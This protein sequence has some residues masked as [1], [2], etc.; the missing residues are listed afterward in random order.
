[1]SCKV[2]Y[3]DGE[4]SKVLAPNGAES[5][6]FKDIL[7]LPEVNGDKEMA[8][9]LYAQTFTPQFKTWFGDWE[10]VSQGK[11]IASG[12]ES[13][14]AQLIKGD[15]EQGMFEIAVQS[16]TVDH[17]NDSPDI[18][19]AI[20]IFGEPLVNLSKALFPNAR[21][22]DKFTPTVSKIV[23]DNGEPLLTYHGTGAKFSEFDFS[24]L[25]QSTKHPSSQLGFFTSSREVASLFQP[26]EQGEEWY[27]SV[28]TKSGILMPLFTSI[29]NPLIL[30]AK[31]F[32]KNARNIENFNI[33]GKDGIIIKGDIS[34]ADIFGGDEY[35]HDNNVIF[36][37]DQ[38]KSVF[39]RGTFVNGDGNIYL[40][41][42][43]N[44]LSSK[45]API[46]LDKV[47]QF[48]HVLGLDENS[49]Q[50]VTEVIHEGRPIKVF[51]MADMLHKSIQIANGK[52]DVTLPEEAMHFLVALVKEQ[53]PKLYESLISNVRDFKLYKDL[54]NSEEY[55]SNE[56]YRKPNGSFDV[57]KIKEE[58]VAKLLA[59]YLINELEGETEKPELLLKV[60]SWWKEILDWIRQ[61][62]GVYTDP[63]QQIT[64]DLAVNN[65]E[66]Y[67]TIDDLNYNGIFLSAASE[68]KDERDIKNVTNKTVF[69]RIKNRTRD[70]KIAK[71]DQKYYKDGVEGKRR[72]SDLVE[73]YYADLFRNK[74]IPEEM[75]PFYEQTRQD[76]TYIHE[77]IEDVMHRLIDAET[78]LVRDEPLPISEAIVSNPVA[79]FAYDYIARNVIERLQTYEEGTR[80]LYEQIVY[81]AARDIYGTIDFIAITPSGKVD[82]LDWKTLYFEEYSNKSG[83]KEYKEKAFNIQIKEYKRILE[84]SY[85]I[86]DFGKLRAIP[87]KKMYRTA[88]DDLGLPTKGRVLHR[89]QMAGSNAREVMDESLRPVIIKEESTGNKKLDTFVNLL[90]KLGEDLKTVRKGDKFD[91]GKY[92]LLKRS[93]YELRTQQ[94]INFFYQYAS[95]E[96]KN[97]RDTLENVDKNKANYTSENIN[98]AL[99][100][101]NYQ[102][103]LIQALEKVHFLVR[104]ESITPESK[105]KLERLLRA[106]DNASSKITDLRTELTDKVAKN[107]GIFNLLKPE[108]VMHF[109]NRYMRTMSQ[110][111]TAAV[112]TLYKMISKVFN[113]V[114]IENSNE[115]K[116]I[117][118]A[119][120]G[121]EEWAKRTG[122]TMKDALSKLLKFNK[123]GTWNGNLISS[124]DTKFYEERTKALNSGDPKAVLTWWSENYNIDKYIEWYNYESARYSDEV[125][126]ATYSEDE[127]VNKQTKAFLLEK[128]EKRFNISKNPFTA[129]GPHNKQAWSKNIKIEKWYSEQYKFLLQDSNKELKAAYDLF[130]SI[131]KE[132]VELGVIEAW[133]ENTFVPNVRKG[134]ADSFGFQDGN[135]ISK[136]GKAIGTWYGDLKDSVKVRDQ[137]INYSG[138]IN[139]LTGEKENKIFAAYIA[140]LGEWVPDETSPGKVKL[141]FSK[142][143]LD[144]FT[145]YSLM[146]RQKLRY[147]YLSEVENIAQALKHVEA[148]KGS[149]ETSKFGKIKRDPQGNIKITDN[150]EDNTE[151]LEK[152]IR[153]SV[154][155]EVIQNDA[156]MFVEVT[157]NK[158]V[159]AWNKSVFGKVK[160]LKETK[161]EKPT[162]ISATKV[163]MKLNNANQLRVLGVNL[164]TA[165]SNLFGGTASTYLINKQLFTS[166]DLTE[167][168]SQMVSNSWYATEDMQKRAALV[169]YFLPLL[170]NRDKFHSTQLS[171]SQSTRILSQEWLMAPQR[172]T[173]HIVQLNIF[174]ATIANT[175]VENGELVNIRKFVQDKNGWNTRYNLSADERS[176]LEK[177]IETEIEALKKE[178]AIVKIATFEK[179]KVG[180]STETIIKIPG[181]SR[182]STTVEHFRQQVQ[183]IT[184]NVLGSSSEFDLAAY[185][186]SIWGRLFMTFKN[187]IPR[188]LD[189]RFGEFRYDTGHDAYEW[190]RAR[191]FYRALGGHW[192][193][194]MIKLVPLIG[195]G[196]SAYEDK[197]YL[198]N[199]AKDIYAEKK[200]IFEE[201]GMADEEQFMKEDEF[202]QAFIQGVDAEFT[203]L[204]T[205][206]VLMAIFLSAILAP[207]DD[208]D[209]ETKSVKKKLL[210][211]VDKLTDEL[212]FAY[213]PQSFIDIM[214]SKPLPV[215]GFIGDLYKVGQQV[216]KQFFGYTFNNEDWEDSAKPMKYIFKAFPVTKEILGYM[217][218]FD[219]EL[220]K[221]MGIRIQ[222]QNRN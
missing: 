180:K 195:R 199:R 192:M 200:R 216:G 94:D 91:A 121:V 155:G 46:T 215:I 21:V 50:S 194:S 108:K 8:L 127:T 201:L 99:A 206:T 111:Q 178:R 126:A 12:M 172:K 140:E 116:N 95:V 92:E 182:E 83:I 13:F 4:V 97:V 26:L 79:K 132:L 183:N 150:N 53:R 1:M 136:T 73:D 221:E 219:P 90:E 74:V 34:R 11:A 89:I 20:R 101:L 154:Y 81:D 98:D 59:E 202:I 117:E 76:G 17:A 160:Q 168:A 96:L 62:F 197:T 86:R 39:N 112:Q 169:D 85:G 66:A 207:D 10:L 29:R 28:P 70:L 210:R 138:Y 212:S 58:A 30:T 198:I 5:K 157:R 170:D 113:R 134:F 55:T 110:S 6:L 67:G 47:K 196:V 3:K 63:F 64:D 115:N 131:N 171:V 176:A 189:V 153:A 119:R 175:M 24:K 48:L 130:T 209:D 109:W 139:P 68:T 41:G 191:M 204:R 51:A 105:A 114:D 181:V 102:S 165:V 18:R 143:S 33:Y 203:E 123:D 37:A 120:A 78:G 222:T 75:K 9:R 107:Y 106:F 25:G 177:K 158:F 161:N 45:A 188:Q 208:D 72:V 162:R 100:D 43:E 56:F 60:R 16:N 211:Q 42:D 65:F 193:R 166:S 88:K 214:G 174:L 152:H 144:L 190:G 15:P 141:D 71:I 135:L 35:I 40:S 156:D 218:I 149:I 27:W 213:S 163:L 84:S 142:K 104:E 31:E 146:N 147:K 44:L 167:A 32:S 133:R 36:N 49:I 61:K 185:K 145:V 128:F 7:S 164:A 52:E 69:D 118:S 125:L 2:I 22:G 129:L 137:E 148:E 179:V 205:I 38:V 173:D 103:D 217:P 220:A 80:F 184:K 54:I 77:I 82:I 57:Q 151:I 187:W 14:Y 87:I 19:E 122:T 124:I 23:D 93:I 186:Y 159:K